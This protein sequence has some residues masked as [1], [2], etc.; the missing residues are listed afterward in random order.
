MIKDLIDAALIIESLEANAKEDVLDEMLAAAVK[1]KLLPAKQSAAVRKL[2]K[3]REKLGSTGIG[4][5]VA[6]PHV[7]AE[8][9]KGTCMV[10]ARSTTGIPY[11]AVDGKDVQTVFMILTPKESAEAHLQV[12]RWI[13]GLARSADFRRFVIGAKGEAE[14]RDLLHEMSE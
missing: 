9:L 1:S 12:L 8:A 13:A 6:V 3:A 4:N 2:L 7:K 14:I 10:L 5:G 11:S